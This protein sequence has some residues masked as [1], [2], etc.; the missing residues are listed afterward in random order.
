MTFSV[1]LG[2]ETAE[3][4]DVTGKSQ[5]EATTTLET[6]G[7]KVRVDEEYSDTVE[8]G[9]VISQDPAAGQQMAKNNIVAIVVSKGVE[10]VEQVKVPNLLDMTLSE[11]Q[12]AC[13]ILGLS[14]NASGDMSG[15]VGDQSPAAGTML[16]IGSAV[17]V[18]LEK[19]QNNPNPSS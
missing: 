5:E 12:T 10:P 15:T 6:A 19:T 13:N 14:L 18:T 8:A 17:N 7:F 16:D 11:A 4:P 3:I 2:P 1:S 9:F